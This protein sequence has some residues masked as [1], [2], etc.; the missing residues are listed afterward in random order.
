MTDLR[1]TQ[2]RQRYGVSLDREVSPAA[3]A[4]RHVAQHA[5]EHDRF[6][7]QL[8]KLKLYGAVV[9]TTRGSLLTRKIPSAAVQL[10]L[11]RP[12]KAHPE[13]WMPA[14]WSASR[15]RQDGNKIS[16]IS[17]VFA[18][19]WVNKKIKKNILAS[20]L[21][22]LSQCRVPRHIPLPPFTRRKI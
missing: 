19:Q 9:V 3:Y 13:R 5:A 4:L 14:M 8:K 6:Q 20:T 21:A 15:A 16:P 1:S 10:Q 2:Y 17:S 12:R 18:P 11:P 22:P 7:F